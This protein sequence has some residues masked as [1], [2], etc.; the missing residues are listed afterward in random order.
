MIKKLLLNKFLQ[1]ELS[2]IKSQSSLHME[3]KYSRR[4]TFCY[5]SLAVFRLYFDFDCQPIN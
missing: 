5:N 1:N 2:A 4:E 3:I